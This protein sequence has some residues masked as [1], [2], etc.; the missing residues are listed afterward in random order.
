[1]ILHL[2]A[3]KR[4]TEVLSGSFCMY[5]MKD[6]DVTVVSMQYLEEQHGTLYPH[7]LALTSPTSGGLRPLSLVFF[8]AF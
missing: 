1:V 2:P 3:V 8:L 5:V 4:L 6:A 7:K